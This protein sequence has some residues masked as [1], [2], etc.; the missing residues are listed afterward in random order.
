[1]AQT[2]AP[3]RR[4][5]AIGRSATQQRTLTAAL[6]LF[7]DHGVSGTSLQMIADRV[8]VTKAAI[9][10]QFKT[11]DEIVLAVAEREMRPLE[12]ALETAEAQKSQ[13]RAREMLLVQVI[14]MAI[15]R[16]RWV[17]A[18][19]NDP[20]MIRLLASHAPLAE[21][22]E[23]I[24]GL[25]LGAAGPAERVRIAMMGAT[26]GATVV[27]PLVADLDDETLRRELLQ[28]ARRL[29]QIGD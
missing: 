24:Y 23:R 15:E 26:I 17:R 19:Q 5:R 2:Q 18:L 7:A 8:G 29:F 21:L 4:L 9:Y 10:Y 16:R 3:L 14:D 28:A 22:M 1:V 12:E 13:A 20:V 11:K 6:D 25:L 27:H